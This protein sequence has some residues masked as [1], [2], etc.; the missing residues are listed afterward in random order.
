MKRRIVLL[1]LVAV[2]LLGGLLAAVAPPDCAAVAFRVLEYY[3]PHGERERVP[4]LPF[5]S[6]GPFLPIG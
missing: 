3:G 5:D 1:A 2:L 6:W 4:A